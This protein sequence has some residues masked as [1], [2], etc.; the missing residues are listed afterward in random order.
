MP[1]RFYPS[2]ING[3]KVN[4]TETIKKVRNP[5]FGKFKFDPETGNKITE[6]IEDRSLY[7]AIALFLEEAGDD[8][9]VITDTEF[10]IMAFFGNKTKLKDSVFQKLPAFQEA[11]DSKYIEFISF[12]NDNNIKFEVDSFIIFQFS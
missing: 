9:Y 5:H 10:G 3:V 2:I 6:H 4:L 8:R 11:D 12:L 7:N 1:V